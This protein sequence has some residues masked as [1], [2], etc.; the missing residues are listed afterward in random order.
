MSGKLASLTF[1]HFVYPSYDQPLL[2]AY[3]GQFECAFVI[4]HPFVRLSG[5]VALPVERYPEEE[6][7]LVYGEKCSWAF[8]IEQT[9]LQTFAKLNQALLTSIGALRKEFQD[10]E[11]MERLQAFLK[12]QRI[13][14]PG[15]GDFEPLV[16]QDFIS[17]FAQA[18]FEE[19]VFVP[20]FAESQ[21]S[22][23]KLALLS[24][25]V[26]VERL[27]IDDL[28]NRET[29]FPYR[30]SLVT[31]DGSF[32]LTVDWDSFFTLLFGPR[33][34]IEESVRRLA[35]EGFFAHDSTRHSWWLV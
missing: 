25:M 31:P 2:T 33:R 24:D 5:E 21:P 9:G 7:I 32:L 20:E 30:G 22:A 1:D 17:L 8:V 23:E 6:Q 27:R 29:K 35:L 18:G 19:L 4:L 14:M 13:W 26:K 34:Y 28:R 15:E 10:Q 11:G 12:D 16:R 3:S